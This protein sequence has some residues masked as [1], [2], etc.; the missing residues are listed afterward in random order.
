MGAIVRLRQILGPG[1]GRGRLG[2]REPAAQHRAVPGCAHHGDTERCAIVR[3]AKNRRFDDQNTTRRRE[4][5]MNKSS[6][7]GR[8]MV[9]GAAWAVA[10]A[11]LAQTEKL[12]VR[13]HWSA[14]GNHA[15]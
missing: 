10:F 3:D 11:A 15:A 13:L 5:R 1:H 8:V 14:W 12:T 6:F 9:V 7:I 2:D 4:T